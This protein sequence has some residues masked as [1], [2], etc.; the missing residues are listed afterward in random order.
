VDSHA[1]IAK[2]AIPQAAARQI[3]NNGR[4]WARCRGWA[5]GR[6]QTFLRRDKRCFYAR[7]IYIYTRRRYP[8]FPGFAG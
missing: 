5:T 4:Q 8:G 2:I 6:A 3:E 1:A 7:A